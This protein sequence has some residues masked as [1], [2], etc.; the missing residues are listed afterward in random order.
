V[1]RTLT[2]PGVS[3]E[4]RFD[5]L[6]PLPAA[7]GIVGVV[8]VVAKVPDGAGPLIGVSRAA[9]LREQ[10]GEASALS[11]EPVLHALANGASEVIVS[12]VA[13][14]TPAT[15]KF[16]TADATTAF[17][18]TARFT[19]DA[20]GLAV[21]VSA[22]SS[23]AAPTFDVTVIR[24]VETIEEFTR[25]TLDDVAAIE[26]A[27]VTVKRESATTAAVAAETKLTGGRAPNAQAWSNAI[28][29][30]GEEARIDLVIAAPDPS[31]NADAVRVLHQALVAH[32]VAMAVDAKPRIAFG[33][34]AATEQSDLAAIAAHSALVRDRRFVLVS[35]AGAHGA[36]AGMVARMNQ[37]DSP[38][39]KPCPL[40]GISAATYR[41]S[42]LN[43][44]LG[45]TTN[46][47]VVQARH[48]RG[49]V[50]LKGISTFG[51]QISVQR[52]T[53]QCIRETKAIATNFIGQLNTV[54]ART[55]LRQ[56]LIATFTRLERAGA[57]V[58]S[59]DG[60][61]PAFV[62]DVYSTQLDFEQG[63]VRIDIAVR[64]VR[65]IDYVYATIRVKN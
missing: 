41:E 24:G 55:A 20:R 35:P 36:V 19:G 65:S 61:D 60:T 62:V 39:F 13:G 2:V 26:S 4:T 64:P 30:L 7:A 28:D 15:A 46:A 22:A 43:T 34:V 51:D 25:R 57:L 10:L 33:S 48:D 5:V 18:A 32:S 56:Q 11:L 9:E 17:T 23:G 58:P 50:V 44:L 14:G 12:P 27:Y 49:V 52:V 31:M 1:P 40:F 63:A 29:L 45:S 38:T 42:Q 37:Q 6:P 59:T 47:L 54:D 8:G 53:D 21:R 16:D 3:V